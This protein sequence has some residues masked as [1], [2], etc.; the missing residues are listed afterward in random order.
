MASQF[1]FIQQAKWLA[2]TLP[3]FVRL[4][5]LVGQWN[6]RHCPL[7]LLGKAVTRAI[8]FLPAFV[9]VI[10]PVLMTVLA[11]PYCFA[12]CLV[13]LLLSCWPLLRVFTQVV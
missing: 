6:P 9:A 7:T 13:R 1:I 12:I 4:A 5:M 2:S 10:W 11:D 8:G 3:G